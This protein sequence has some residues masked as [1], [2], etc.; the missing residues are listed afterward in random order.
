MTDIHKGLMGKTV[1]CGKSTDGI[2]NKAEL[3]KVYKN[4]KDGLGNIYLKKCITKMMHELPLYVMFIPNN[5]IIKGCL[6]KCRKSSYYYRKKIINLCR[7]TISDS[8]NIIQIYTVDELGVFNNNINTIKTEVKNEYYK[9]CIHCLENIKVGLYDNDQ[10]II[11][12]QLL[13]LLDDF[14]HV[15]FYNNEKKP[16]VVYKMMRLKYD[17]LY[18]PLDKY[19]S[20][21]TQ[22]NILKIYTGI[23]DIRF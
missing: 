11:T 18:V 15:S 14:I 20:I 16:C 3:R 12:N 23:G 9:K 7:Q 21:E 8:E 10:D 6:A 2:N 13:R 4:L 5:K 22:I 17:L 19:S 1:T